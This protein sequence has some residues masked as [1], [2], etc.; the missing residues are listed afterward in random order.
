MPWRRG[1]YELPATSVESLLE[2][3]AQSPSDV[4]AD[5]GSGTGS[6]VIEA[7][8]T[9][10]VRKAI[11]VEIEASSREKARLA[12][13]RS[14][15]RDQLERVDFW[16]GD[17]YSDD[18]DYGEV[19]AVYNSFEESEEEVS[20]YRRRFAA[21]RLRVI[22][23]DLPLVG[24]APTRAV[25]KGRVW[26]FRTDFPPR[27]I[28]KKSEWAQLALGRSTASIDD[29]YLHYREVLTKRGIT[30]RETELDLNQVR[31]LSILRL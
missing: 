3:A 27:R 18:F 29:V 19:T 21:R 9:S 7:A 30:R 14:L 1:A 2:L 6:V 13:I 26:L 31:H 10:P 24:Y 4:F 28:R 5:L 15:N 23:K 8:R 17:I 16:M 11:G 25:R 22:K 12:A 20:F